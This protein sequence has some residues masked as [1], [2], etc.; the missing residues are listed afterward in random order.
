MDNLLPKVSATERIHL[1]QRM[2]QL[3][4]CIT[5]SAFNAICEELKV[6][7][8]DKPGVWQYIGGWCGLTCVWRKLWLKFGRLFNYGYVDTTNIVERHCQFIKYTIMRGII[9]R[10]ITNHVHVL[11][12]DSE[13]NT[14]I[15]GTIV[16]WYKNDKIY[17]FE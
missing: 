15:G 3:M 10:S 4:Q 9:N 12:G 1:Y 14:C 11:I 16:E 5:E 17:M 7:Y 8:A 6:E 2:C 13:T